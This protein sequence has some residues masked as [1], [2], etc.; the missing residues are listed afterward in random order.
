MKGVKNREDNYGNI[1]EL[2]FYKNKL[3]SFKKI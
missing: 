2:G 3:F 1:W